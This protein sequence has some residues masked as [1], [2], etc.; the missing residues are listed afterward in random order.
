[1]LDFRRWFDVLV[2]MGFLGT[3]SVAV[4]Q[5]LNP[6]QKIQYT[7]AA[8]I[9]AKVQLDKGEIAHARLLL[10]GVLMQIKEIA[11]AASANAQMAEI[12]GTY[13]D[14]RSLA[15]TAG[16]EL[17]GGS[18][19]AF[20]DAYQ[21]RAPE[22]AALNQ[23]VY[24]DAMPS[25]VKEYRRHVASMVIGRDAAWDQVAELCMKAPPPDQ[26]I[27]NP[28]ALQAVWQAG[29]PKLLFYVTFAGATGTMHATERVIPETLQMIRSELEEAAGKTGADDIWR[30]VEEAFEGLDLLED[31]EA[32]LRS[33]PDVDLGSLAAD[34]AALRTSTEAQ[35]ARAAQ[36]KEKEIDA[37]RMPGDQWAGGDRGAVQGQVKAAYSAWEPSEQILKVNLLQNGYGERWE[38][39]WEGST[40]IKDYAGYVKAALGVK[41]ASGKHWVAVC[42]FKRS[43]RADGTWSGLTMVDSV[44]NYPIR[45]ANL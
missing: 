14:A 9:E 11:P 44:Y 26:L 43:R 41:D 34:L 37:N 4:G 23:T 29:I 7:Q 17:D 3:S 18:L 22:Y 21:A 10:L 12:V 20:M 5:N 32:A 1:M 27:G 6:M 16:P 8:A 36:L 38:S 42:W 13:M 33:E 15:W 40:L 25:G 19:Q 45:P 35:N 30:H 24:F 31:L 39:W 28:A 2:V